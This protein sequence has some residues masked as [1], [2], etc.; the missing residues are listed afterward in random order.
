MIVPG[1]GTEVED[2]TLPSKGQGD[3]ADHWI[4][5]AGIAALAIEAQDLGEALS[6]LVSNKECRGATAPPT[7]LS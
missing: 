2:T 1:S 6:A 7:E 5:A 3:I 4:V